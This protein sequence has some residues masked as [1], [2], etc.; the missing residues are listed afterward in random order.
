M[1]PMDA[2]MN[3]GETAAPPLNIIVIWQQ[4]LANLVV[5]YTLPRVRS[6]SHHR[7]DRILGQA[8]AFGDPYRSD[9][10]LFDEAPQIADLS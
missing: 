10:G 3:Q 9:K 1:T 4:R 5:H 6:Q 7:R 8:P 2:L